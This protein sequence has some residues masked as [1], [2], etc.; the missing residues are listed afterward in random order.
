MNACPACRRFLMKSVPQCPFCEAP[1]PPSRLGR[2]ASA[3]GASATAVVL[4][5]CYGGG[6][7]WGTGYSDS[8]DTGTTSEEPDVLD[9]VTL[10]VTAGG[11]ALS[12]DPTE[13]AYDFGVIEACDTP[14]SCW[15]A[16]GC[17][18]PFAGY[19]FCHDAGTSGLTLTKVDGPDEVV[20]SSTTL[21]DD[22]FSGT[23]GYMLDD[24]TECF[25][26]GEGQQ[27]FVDAVGCTVQ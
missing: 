13:A 12:I 19:A 11:I 23:L 27:Y 1:V 16:E 14:G 21:F 3:M 8:G 7:K 15:V 20:S 9:R 4:A 17:V 6:D 10:S 25:A 18:E 22:T 24:G 2:V 26:W 5:A